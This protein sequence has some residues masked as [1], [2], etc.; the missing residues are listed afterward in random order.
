MY[1]PLVQHEGA[2]LQLHVLNPDK[3][4]VLYDPSLILLHDAFKQGRSSGLVLADIRVEYVID[5]Q[6]E[7]DEEQ[8]CLQVEPARFQLEGRESERDQESLH[9][10][11][12]VSACDPSTVDVL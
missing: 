4:V 11:E 6:N 5:V 8:L 12:P 1:A 9:F 10:Q 2:I 7:H 3:A